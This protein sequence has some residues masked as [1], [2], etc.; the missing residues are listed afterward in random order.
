MVRRLQTNGEKDQETRGPGRPAIPKGETLN[1]IIRPELK[2]M[3][4]SFREEYGSEK[5]I[6]ENI[7]DAFSNFTDEQKRA[8][9]LNPK[10][11]NPFAVLLAQNDWSAHTFALEH[12]SWAI[13]CYGSLAEQYSKV[14]AYSTFALYRKGYAWMGFA[15]ELRAKA[16]EQVG[17]R[18]KWLRLFK[19]AIDSVERGIDANQRAAASESSTPFVLYNTACG[20]SLLA[21][22]TVE[23]A[24][25][26]KKG[27]AQDLRTKGKTREAWKVIGEKWR[28]ETKTT[29][30]NFRTYVN[31][32]DVDTYAGNAIGALKSINTP[33]A[34]RTIATRIGPWPEPEFFR[35]RARHDSDLIFLANDGT[36]GEQFNNWVLGG[37]KEPDEAEWLLRTYEDLKEQNL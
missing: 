18:A 20:Y 21:Q 36:Y 32:E 6:V 15:L 7:L 12:W 14:P 9:L 1:V 17:D 37:A 35:L 27:W 19:A 26:E 23:I 5:S 8:V 4:K 31:V 3:L 25:D 16:F 10:S 28:D 13:Q 29:K 11:F 2:E 34:E 24:L 22:F 30:N 33:S